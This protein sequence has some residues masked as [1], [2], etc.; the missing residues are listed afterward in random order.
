MNGFAINS[1]YLDRR[2]NHLLTAFEADMDGVGR[3]RGLS[4]GLL[5]G[6]GVVQ[7]GLYAT[8][9]DF[10]R[11]LPE[12]ERMA[13]T[14]QYESLYDFYPSYPKSKD[15]P[16]EKA[17]IKFVAAAVV[18]LFVAIAAIMWRRFNRFMFGRDKF[19]RN[20]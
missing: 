2:R 8:P 11:I 4:I 5:G 12:F 17:M 13:R 3:I 7:L 10:E 15:G 1:C 14:F 9:K 16:F 18:A 6:A 19:F 20:S